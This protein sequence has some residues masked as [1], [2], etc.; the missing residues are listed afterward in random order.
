MRSFDEKSGRLSPYLSTCGA[1]SLAFGCAVGWGAFVMPGTAFLPVAG[2][3]GTLI[4]LGVGAAVMFLIGRNYHYL[5]QNFPEAGGA[6]GYVK[7]VCG[8]DHG[9]ICGWFLILTYVAIAWANATA[10]AL[11]GRHLLGGFFSFGFKYEISGYDVYAGEILLS[12]VA[13]L[14]IGGV[15]LGGK[16][17]AARVQTFFAL[18]L[19]VGIAVCVAAVLVK[20]Q[21][22]LASFA[23]AFAEGKPPLLQ[24]IAVVALAP[25]A[26]VGFESV[27]HSAEEFAFPRWRTV[28]IIVISL[29]AATAAYAALTLVA[30]SVHPPGFANWRDYMAARGIFDGLETL[31]VFYAVEKSIGGAGLVILCVTT[32]AAIVTGLI[33]HIVAAS[34]LLYAMSRDGLLWRAFG[35]LDHDGS[36]RNAILAIIAVSCFIPL[37][38]RT[39]VGWVVD[40]TTVGASIAYG[41]VSFCTIMVARKER[42]RWVMATGVA[43][44]VVSAAFLVYFLVPNFWV[45]DALTTESYFIL[46]AWSVIGIIVFR[47]VFNR[48]RHGRLGTTTVAWVVL[49]LFIFVSGHLWNR[50]KTRLLTDIVVDQISERYAPMDDDGSLNEEERATESFLKN[51]EDWVNAEL[52]RYNLI[53]IAV[54]LITLALMYSI[55]SVISRREKEAA[56]AKSYFF[57]TISHDIRTPLNAIV[58]FSQMLKLGFRTK[59]EADEAVSSILTSSKSLLSLVNDILDLSRRESGKADLHPLPTDCHALLREVEESFRIGFPKDGVEI[60]AAI[61]EMPLLLVDPLLLRHAVVNLV[62]NAVKFTEKGFVEVRGH[63]DRDTDGDTGRLVIEIEDTGVGISDE[64]KQK[65][66]SPYMQT[67]SKMSRNGGTG[68]GLAV[69]RQFAEMMGGTMTFDSELGKGSTFWITLPKVKVVTGEVGENSWS[70]REVGVQSSSSRKD[71]KF[72]SP[73][74]NSNHHSSSNSNSELQL[75]HPRLLLVDD[76]KMNLAVLKA[77]VKRVGGFEVE[78][79]ADGREALARLK[80]PDAPKI[81]AVLTD[82]WMPE[83][84]GEGLAKAIRA[85]ATLS[86]TPVHVITADVELQETYAEKGFDSIILKPVT[87]GTLGPILAGLAERNG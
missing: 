24:V 80:N 27:S 84:D 40:V 51:Q 19:G 62:S 12:V 6:Y 33:G 83:L 60:R 75:A 7:K 77:L 86:H 26:F 73:T 52:T 28:R 39:A 35:R 49:L 30:A 25:W 48:D 10:L 21:G 45:V 36:P 55:Y 14:L 37:V 68:L 81:D 15:F 16:R 46:S 23:P 65:I 4:G 13:L 42:R 66:D 72:H 8:G 2:P 67:A 38:G 71:G 57:S 43:G 64:D 53:Q 69:C 59:E 18:V 17:F 20:H 74:Q 63:F 1:V 32:I 76:Q 79:A 22:G 58:G 61:G 78:T 11:I 44:V 85:D 47:G 54:V 87:V 56:K 3:L 31:P 5:I 9:Y 70:S 50:Q 82:M 29:V 34:R 41:Y